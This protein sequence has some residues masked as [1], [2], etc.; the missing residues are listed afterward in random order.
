[1]NSFNSFPF[2]GRRF[3]PYTFSETKPQMV[4][5]YLNI[6]LFGS[7]DLALIQGQI[8]NREILKLMECFV[9]S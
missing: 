5:T 9:L 3:V 1:M 8:Y 7:Q 2:Q 4:S 6:G